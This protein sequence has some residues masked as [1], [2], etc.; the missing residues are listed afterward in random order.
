LYAFLV[1]PMHA[2]C[3]DQLIFP[4][5][6]AIVFMVS[7]K[8]CRYWYYVKLFCTINRLWANRYVWCELYGK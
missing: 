4:D 7:D 3:L 1:S 6:I 5:L 8:G 2:T